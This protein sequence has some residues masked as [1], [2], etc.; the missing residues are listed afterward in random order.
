MSSLR[1]LLCI[2]FFLSGFLS[3]SLFFPLA[4]HLSLASIPPIPPGPQPTPKRLREENMSKLTQQTR[5]VSSCIPSI[6]VR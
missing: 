5:W 3:L 6:G 2:L 1:L 4:F